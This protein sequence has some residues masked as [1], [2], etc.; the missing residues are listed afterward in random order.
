MNYSNEVWNPIRGIEY[1]Y[2]VSSMGRVRSRYKLLTPRAVRG[3][4]Y[5]ILEISDGEFRFRRNIPVHRLVAQEFHI[6]RLKRKELNHIDGNKLNNKADNLEWVS[7]EENQR[8]AYALGLHKMPTGRMK[9]TKETI[10]SVFTLRKLDW[11]HREIAEKLGMGISTVTHTL[12][13]SRRSKQ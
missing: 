4:Y 10:N 2:H 9:F 3:Y 13:G 1:Y 7:R 12:L 8:H 11:T 5:V 6:N